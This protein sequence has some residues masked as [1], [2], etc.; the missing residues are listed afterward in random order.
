M[1]SKK[2]FDNIIKRN[3]VKN[4][5]DSVLGYDSYE[6]YYS[7]AEFEKFKTEMQR[8]EYQEFYNRYKAGKGCELEPQ[9]GKSGELPPK[10]ASV[11]SSSRFCYL[12]FRDMGSGSVMVEV[13]CRIKGILGTP[14]QLDAYISTINT[15]FEVKCHEIFDSH[16]VKMSNN[17]WDLLYGKDNDFGLFAQKNNS[18]TFN[19]PLTEFDIE[20]KTS[21]FDIKQLL[22]HLLGISS[23]KDVVENV[24]LVY[25]F[26][27]P[28]TDSD[29]DSRSIDEVF[30]L[31]QSEIKKIFNSKPI[32]SF[33]TK[34]NITLSAIAEFSE[35]MEPLTKENT[36]VLA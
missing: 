22:C 2:D 19:I 12:A 3:I 13:P 17:Y 11:A 28:K 20:T 34:N 6:N 27:K 14:P 35:V 21:M 36:I 7:C 15:Y 25:L 32:K 23:Q 5:D 10:M 16:H 29:E 4:K 30:D 33:T 8:P 26:F 1:I 24:R 31:L 18:K 9:Q